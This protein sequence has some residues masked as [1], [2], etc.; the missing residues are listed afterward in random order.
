[1]KI[2]LLTLLSCALLSAAALAQPSDAPD[3][4]PRGERRVGPGGPS[5]PGSFLRRL[6]L[7]VALDTDGDGEISPKE[8]K[9]A[10]VALKTLDKDGNGR[11][12]EDELRP[13]FP[14]GAP[15]GPGGPVG[16]RQ[17]GPGAF[18]GPPNPEAFVT[19]ALEFDEDMDGKLSR[20]ELTKMAQQLG[21]REPRGEAGGPGGNRTR[22]QRP[23][24]NQ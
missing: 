24:P 15:G 18:G 11:L 3:Q 5:G 9:R 16:A 17:G 8:I 22:Q 7:M 23:D 4:P 13:E 2:F 6:P 1:M 20:E 14:G 10:I 19:R 12:T 21:R